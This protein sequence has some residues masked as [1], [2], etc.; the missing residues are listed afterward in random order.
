MRAVHVLFYKP[1][2]DDFW[3]NHVVVAFS[4]PYSHCD[5]QFDD[6]IASSVYQNEAVYMEAK[7]FSRLNYE[8]VSLTFTDDEYARIFKFCETSYRTRV[9]FDLTGM[10]CA[11]LPWRS[12]MPTDKTFCSRYI[13][14]ALNESHRDE[15]VK[16]DPSSVTPSS[17]HTKLAEN[18]RRFIDVSAGRMRQLL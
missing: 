17:L 6:G 13:C 8:R 14:E 15:F 9:G 3:L 7:K 16:L 2:A 1:Q 12:R 11:Y 10:L 5:I 4:P 18:N